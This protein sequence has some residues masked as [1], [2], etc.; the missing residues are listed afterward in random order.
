MDISSLAYIYLLIYHIIIPK[1]TVTVL[2][3][4]VI[5]NF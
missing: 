4:F 2:P 5:N 3:L 1:H